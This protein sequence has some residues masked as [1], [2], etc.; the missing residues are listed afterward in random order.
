M[1]SERRHSI[2]KL[3]IEHYLRTGEPIGSK[4]LCDLL[5]YSV[6]SATIRNEMA[7]LTEPGYLEQRHTSGGRVP[8]KASYRYYV[9]NLMDAAELTDYEK[10]RISESLSVNSGDPERLLADAAKLLAEYTHCA[11]FCCMLEDESDCVQGVELIPAGKSKATLVM[12]T[13]GSKVKASLVNLQCEPDDE[14]LIAFYKVINELV[15]GTKL[16]DITPA[17]M[18]NAA[19]M[20]AD[21]IFDL[22]PALSSLCSLCGEAAGSKLTLEGETNLLSHRE[23]GTDIYRLLTFLTEKKQLVRLISGF[24]ES[25]LTRAVLLGD[26]NPLYEMKNTASMIAKYDYGNNQKAAVGIIGGLRLDYE[27]VIPRVK[28]ITDTAERLL[29]GGVSL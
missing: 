13:A 11:A 23:L 7:Y 20:A 3:V 2:L 5:P 14:Y 21:R 27:N 16:T 15:T 9:D 18:Q 8:T 25:K 26:E 17:L 28:Y 24:A 10:S 19:A 12:L 22:L 6:S 1:I 4:T 29:S